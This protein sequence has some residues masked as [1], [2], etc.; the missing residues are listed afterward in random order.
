MFYS[1][2][3][4]SQKFASSMAIPLALVILDITGYVPN[5][6]Q[7]PPNAIL[8]IRF[9]TGPIPAITLCIGIVFAILYPLR[10]ERYT[11]I[12]QELED[13]RTATAAEEG[14]DL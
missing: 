11:Q 10:R 3:S 4:I 7:Q 1:L 5:S 8:G 2:I 13:R 14:S 6:T 12:A 9:L